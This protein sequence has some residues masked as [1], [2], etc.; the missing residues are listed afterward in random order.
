M[1]KYNYFYLTF[2]DKLNYQNAIILVKSI[3]IL[4]EYFMLNFI[5]FKNLN[6]VLIVIF[7]VISIS[8]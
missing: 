1:W 4:N 8:I 6:T 3:I 7:H 5:K 2:I